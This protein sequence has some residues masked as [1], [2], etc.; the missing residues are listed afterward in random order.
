MD[1]GISIYRSVRILS[2]LDTR[3]ISMDHICSYV[4]TYI[5]CGCSFSY[6]LGV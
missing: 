5:H 3:K 1:Q 4:W 6:E 2:D